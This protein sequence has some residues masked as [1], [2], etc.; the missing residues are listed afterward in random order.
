MDIEEF[1]KKHQPRAK[2]SKL[3]PYQAQIFELK[4]KGYANWQVC[5]WLAE[6]G[7]KISQEAVRKFIKSRTEKGVSSTVLH[8]TEQPKTGNDKSVLHNTEPPEQGQETRPE[9]GT[10]AAIDEVLDKE[11]RKAKED[12]YLGGANTNP[13]FRKGN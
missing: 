11:K 8:N 4:S 2:S 7:V 1:A 9:T 10:L 6:N 3:D 5:E 13:L 12:L